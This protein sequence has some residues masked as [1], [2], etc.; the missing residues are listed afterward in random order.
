[1]SQGCIDCGA[2]I[3]TIVCARCRGVREKRDGPEYY[4]LLDDEWDALHPGLRATW[5]KKPRLSKK[6]KPTLDWDG[7]E[8]VSAQ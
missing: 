2:P 6:R 1:M 4:K 7:N 5:L 8:I 3:C